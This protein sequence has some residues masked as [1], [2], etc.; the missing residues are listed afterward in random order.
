MHL[1]SEMALNIIFLF[2]ME[3]IGTKPPLSKVSSLQ[4]LLRRQEISAPDIYFCNEI[5]F[6]NVQMFFFLY[7]N[8]MCKMEALTL[9]VSKKWWQASITWAASSS[10]TSLTVPGRMVM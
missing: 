3:K 1:E 8:K 2:Y 10:F 6:F 9:H 4:S 7:V 5:L